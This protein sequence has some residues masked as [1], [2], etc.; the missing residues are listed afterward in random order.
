MRLSPE[1]YKEIASILAIRTN[2]PLSIFY[3]G[4]INAHRWKQAVTQALTL[5]DDKIQYW[6]TLSLLTESHPSHL[7][8]TQEIISNF[9]EFFSDLTDRFEY[10]QTLIDDKTE[11]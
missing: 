5:M 7:P 6:H 9:Q 1:K 11:E 3:D 8:D 2:A 4:I 10:N